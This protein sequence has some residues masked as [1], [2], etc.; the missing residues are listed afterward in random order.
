[1]ASSKIIEKFKQEI[2]SDARV[3]N[4]RLSEITAM[5]AGGVVYDVTYCPPL[6]NGDRV[7]AVSYGEVRE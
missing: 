2:S 7:T 6:V 3:E 5:K 1:M 4:G